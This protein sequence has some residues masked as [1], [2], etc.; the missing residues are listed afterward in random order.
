MNQEQYI[1]EL[2]EAL[3]DLADGYNAHDLIGMTGASEERCEEIYLTVS[4]ATE[5]IELRRKN[6]PINCK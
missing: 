3:T 5:E 2:E 4:R 6:K 1:K